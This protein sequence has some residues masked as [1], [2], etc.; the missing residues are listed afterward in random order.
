MQYTILLNHNENVHKV[1]EEERLKFIRSVLEAL[2]ITQL[3]ECW[4]PNKY[5]LSVEERIAV[6]ELLSKYG[7]KIISDEEVEIYLDGELVGKFY[8]SLFKMK[9][10][11]VGDFNTL[12]LEMN[13]RNWTIF[14]E[15]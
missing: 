12:Y 2:E 10:D 14:E 13:V 5:E 1:E 6:R 15:E 7:I 3:N 4:E 9:Q 11:K 8:K